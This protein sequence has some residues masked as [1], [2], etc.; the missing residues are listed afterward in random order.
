M[1]GWQVQRSTIGDSAGDR[2]GI[3]PDG[4]PFKVENVIAGWRDDEAFRDLFIAELAASPYPAF[5]WE[6]PP[7]SPDTL[8]LPFECAVI[9]TGAFAGLRA[10]DSDFA[11]QLAGSPNS[12]VNFANLGGDAQLIVPKRTSAADCY[13][14]IGAFVREGPREQ[15]HALFRLLAVEAERLLKAGRRFWISTSG[16]GVPWV[17][18]RLDSYPKYYQHRP[19]AER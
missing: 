8:G 1:T 7:V 15:Q 17:H 4:L 3:G 10:D 11:E 16:L 9:G 14:H 5:F 19:Y 2:I 12:V 6:M 18:V 13:A